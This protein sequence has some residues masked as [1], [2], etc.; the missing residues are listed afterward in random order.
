M[1]KGERQNSDEIVTKGKK[2]NSEWIKKEW[3]SKTRHVGFVTHAREFLSVV[4]L[5]ESHD[6]A[7]SKDLFWSDGRLFV[8]YYLLCHAIEL[9]LKSYLVQHGYTQEELRKMGHNLCKILA[10]M[11]EI[12]TEKNECSIGHSLVPPYLRRA[13]AFLSDLYLKKVFEY[14]VRTGTMCSGEWPCVKTMLRDIQK[15]LFFLNH[16]YVADSNAEERASNTER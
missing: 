12:L 16:L 1:T 15:L 2:Q 4:D 11:D 8:K 3:G 9:G 7:E 10:E 13:I 6:A 5:I 14:P